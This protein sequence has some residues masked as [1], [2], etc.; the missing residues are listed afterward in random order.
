MATVIL[1]SQDFLRGRFRCEALTGTHPCKA[2]RNPNPNTN[3]VHFRR[4]K[5][6]PGGFQSYQLQDRDRRGRS[7]S[8]STVVKSPGKDPVMGQVKILKR[9]EVLSPP[10]AKPYKDSDLVLFS[11]DRIGPAPETMCKQVRV[12][13]FKVVDGMFA[14]SAF[15]ASPPPSSLPVPGFLGKKIEENGVATSSLR[16]LLGLDFV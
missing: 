2:R 8:R 16:R 12:S 3:S 5:R 1:R 10:A 4:R 14:G 15:F 11:T 7:Q 6:S 9:G 13:K